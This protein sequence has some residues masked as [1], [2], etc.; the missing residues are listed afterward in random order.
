V[1][2]QYETRTAERCSAPLSMRSSRR[3][4]ENAKLH[5]QLWVAQKGG[6][7]HALCGMCA[8]LPLVQ[9][10]IHRLPGCEHPPSLP[11]A[12]LPW[13][14]ACMML[15]RCVRCH[16][17]LKQP[18]TWQKLFG[19]VP[20]ACIRHTPEMRVDTPIQVREL[21]TALCAV[22]ILQ[23]LLAIPS[24]AKEVAAACMVH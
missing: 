23:G 11:S 15:S 1:Y 24:Y 18:R 20:P 10:G 3:C 9:F 22:F 5:T 8:R 21:Q 19:C 13:F 14:T 2:G 7:L 16:I 4:R 6:T 12:N 17:S